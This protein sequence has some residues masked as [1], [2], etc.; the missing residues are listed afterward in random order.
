MIYAII[1]GLLLGWIYT[2]TQPKIEQQ[3]RMEREIAIKEVMPAST[4]VFVEDTLADGTVIIIGYEDEQK[5]KV[6]GYASVAIGGGFSSNIK[7]MVGFSPQLKVNAIKV[8]SQNETPGLGTHIQDDWFQKQFSDKSVEQ[9]K[10]DKDGGKIESI[11]GATISSRA[12]TN[13]ISALVEK[14]ST[15]DELPGYAKEKKDT[16]VSSDTIIKNGVE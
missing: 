14:L 9:L 12:V 13:S 8:I 15:S 1:A 3:A 16:I 5:S 2:K 10:V 4:S 11:T 6:A 7:T